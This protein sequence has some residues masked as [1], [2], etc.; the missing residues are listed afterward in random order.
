MR[1]TPC[2]VSLTEAKAV[3]YGLQEALRRNKSSIVV[4]GDNEP[5]M[6]TLQLCEDPCSN[7]VS[8]LIR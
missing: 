7:I 4:E 5:V 2:L 8:W 3:L 1:L 6:R